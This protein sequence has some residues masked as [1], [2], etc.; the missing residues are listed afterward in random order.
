MYNTYLIDGTSFVLLC[1]F[2]KKH[3]FCE[4]VTVVHSVVDAVFSIYKLEEFKK[5][6]PVPNIC[7]SFSILYIKKENKKQNNTKPNKKHVYKRKFFSVP[8]C[9]LIS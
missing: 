7:M 2:V 5:K 4:V 1:N 3:N 6:I 8:C 9:D